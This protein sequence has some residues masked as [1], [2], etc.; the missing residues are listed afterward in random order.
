MIW[1][2]IKL[3][4]LYQIVA[5]GTPSRSRLD[6]FGGKI[7]W[8]KISD[9]L[10]GRITQTEEYLNESGLRNCNAKILP[11]GTILISI[12]ATVGRTAVLDVD[13]TTNQAIVG[14]LPKKNN[15]NDRYIR[16]ALDSLINSL[17]DQSRGV[18]QNNINQSILAKT[19]IPFPP[20]PI[21]KQVAVLLEKADAA[22]EKRRKANQLTEQF[23]QS[24]FLEMFGDPVT[25]PKGWE[26]KELR[27]V[28]T[29]IGG[30]AFKSEDYVDQGIPLIKI[31]TV[32][33]GYVKE[34]TIS[35]LP[36]KF[37]IK[38]EKFKLL[39]DDMVINLTGTTGKEDYGNVLMLPKNFDAY[40]LNQRVAR[41]DYNK[42][43]LTKEFLYFAFKQPSVRDS[44]IRF[45]RGV[46]QANISNE[47]ILSTKIPIPLISKQQKFSDLVEKIES[48][49]AKQRESEKEL[50]NLFQSLMQR[51][52][53]GEL[54]S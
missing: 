26:K 40:L 46:R 45:N 25:N 32:N 29:L 15:V 30:F 21:Q 20:L 5:G 49:R 9:M 51:A 42:I 14:L 16:F 35:F 10:Q 11:K 39:P 37:L 31:G 38:H 1:P 8:V 52:F 41:I 19:E 22:R 17:K 34:E 33:R 12:F 18:A 3:G 43:C 44:I 54:V 53:K 47:D 48:L 50:E 2:R 13:A 4:E 6:Y 27:N 24:T 7:P 23:L 28:V 36:E